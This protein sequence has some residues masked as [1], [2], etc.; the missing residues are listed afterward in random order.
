MS[1]KE[2]KKQKKEKV[3]YID[4]GSTI[5]DMSYVNAKGEKRA[6]TQKRPKQPSTASD[7][8]HTYVTAVKMMFKPMLVVLGAM[9]II[10]LL[11]LLMAGKLF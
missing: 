6:P 11:F 2:K 9:T 5:A 10:Y 3:V 1:K 7:R 8:W 4:D